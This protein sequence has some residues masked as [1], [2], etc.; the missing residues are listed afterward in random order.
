[1]RKAWVIVWLLS[2]LLLAFPATAS[3]SVWDEAALIRLS[4]E[5]MA[6]IERKD[7]ASLERIVASEFTLRMLG[8]AQDRIVHRDE[9]LANAIGMD[10]SE[11]SYENLEAGVNGDQ[12]IVHVPVTI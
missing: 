4:N 5:W 10:W 1:M 8:D 2:S 7:R 11:F 12:A 9:W 3:P 6:A